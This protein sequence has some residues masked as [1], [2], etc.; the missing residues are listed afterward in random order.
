MLRILISVFLPFLGLLILAQPSFSQQP[1]PLTN[2]DV[3]KMVKSGVPESVI[4]LSI[5]TNPT[6]F[7]VSANGL[8]AL[9]K[10]AVSQKVMTAILTAQKNKQT[11]VSVSPAGAPPAP[12][13]PP[14]GPPAPAT[15][16]PV[17][18]SPPTPAAAQASGQPSVAFFR[19]GIVQ[20]IPV[21]KSQQAATKTPPTSMSV[22]ASDSA[23]TQGLEAGVNT[24]VFGATSQVTS[25]TGNAALSQSSAIF[26]GILSKRKPMVTYVWAVQNPNS[27]NMSSTSAPV[28]VVNF[29]GI[30]GVNP[31]EFEPAV[32]QLTPSNN[33]RLV[34]ATRGKAEAASSPTVD[35]QVYSQFVEDRV[36]VQS[37]KVGPG[38]YQFAVTSPLAPG[39]YAVVLRPIS[40]TKQFSGTAIARYQGDGIMF[41]GVWSFQV[42]ASAKP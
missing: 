6:D 38:Q 36:P 34:G 18:V 29:A 35:W 26:T 7:D 41:D 42:P 4:V 37:Q 15:A 9:Q 30:I 28:F 32:V 39:E 25:T 22:L 13:P 21:E 33:F 3:I 8:I 31:D 10:A 24:A 19:G 2:S 1:K 23:L 27:T 17:S 20:E 11:D 40:K 14:G 12:G 16:G 5:Q